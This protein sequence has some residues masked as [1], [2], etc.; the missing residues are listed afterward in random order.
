MLSGNPN[1]K[2]QRFI[3]GLGVWKYRRDIGFQPDVQFAE[4]LPTKAD[5]SQ[6]QA[7]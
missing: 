4:A 2:S 6:P 1:Q 7:P 3:D 5:L